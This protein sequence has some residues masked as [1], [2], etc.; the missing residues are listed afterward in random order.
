MIEFRFGRGIFAGAIICFLSSLTLATSAL[1]HYER[2]VEA[3]ET[4]IVFVHGVLGDGVATWTRGSAYWPRLLTQDKVFDG[5]SVYVHQYPTGL[6]AK[7]S[8]DELADNMRLQFDANEVSSHKRIIFLAH[9]M[10]GLI[11]RSYLL[12]YRPVATRTAFI[13]FYSTP[14]TGSEVASWVQL[15]NAQ[16]R[17]MKLLE[18]DG[19]LGD[20]QRQWVNARFFIPSYCAYEKG[21]TYALEIV[22]QASAGGLCNWSLDPIDADHIGIVKPANESHAS[23]LAFKNAFREQILAAVPAQPK[24]MLAVH[25]LFKSMYDTY[26]IELG[27]PRAPAQLSDDA[28]LAEYDG[29]M[30]V[31]I[32]PLLTIFYLPHNVD[33]KV[34]RQPD[35]V[36]APPELFDDAHLRR[37]FNTPGDR[38][39]PHGGVAYH[40]QK[41]PER[42]KWVGWRQWFCRYFD[43]VFYQEF[44]SGTI[45]GPFHINPSR[46]EGQVFVVF[47][48][49][50]RHPRIASPKV[51]SCKP[52]A[53]PHVKP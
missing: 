21:K 38:Y 31:W 30:I 11:T 24:P 51:P 48:D 36:W 28:Y 4:V 44:E 7:L 29:S 5:V 18:S 12:K 8:I 47:N 25:P 35:T 14:T 22:T 34:I 16:F 9:S 6:L 43:E 15:V 40:W 10:G 49:G 52:I 37:L 20:L 33:R 32:K 41:D 1:P 2:K 46:P 53:D 26:S 50:A 39:P 45:F 13:Y 3:A 23:Y 19:Y 17:A 27:R 42:W